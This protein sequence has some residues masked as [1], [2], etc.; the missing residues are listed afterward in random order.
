LTGFRKRK[1]QRTCPRRCPFIAAWL[2]SHASMPSGPPRKR[3]KR[4]LTMTLVPILTRL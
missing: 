1:G 3:E 4:Y 2:P